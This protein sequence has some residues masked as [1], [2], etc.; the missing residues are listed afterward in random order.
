MYWV[1]LSLYI[2]FFLLIFININAKKYIFFIVITLSILAYNFDPIYVYGFG[3]NYY[4]DLIRI[5]NEIE[6]VRQL[7]DEYLYESA[8][9]SKIYISLFAILND[10]NLLPFFTC[11]F[12]YSIGLYSIYKIG[13]KSKCSNRLILCSIFMSVS[14]YNYL[15]VITNIRYLLALTIFFVILYLDLVCKKRIYCI[16]YII[17]ILFHPG[18]IILLIIRFLTLKNIKNSVM[19]LFMMYIC[20]NFFLDDIFNI[21]INISNVF[22]SGLQSKMLI[23][24]DIGN[25][26]KPTMSFYIFSIIQ[27]SILSIVIYDIKKYIKVNYF[28]SYKYFINIGILIVIISVMMLSNYQLLY[29]ITAILYLYLPVIAM[30]DVMNLRIQRKKYLMVSRYIIFGILI[31]ISCI[32]Y[33]GQEYGYNILMF[34]N[35]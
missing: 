19:I 13:K 33:F 18:I 15:M 5:F 17:D 34:S 3:D 16:G 24:R 4:T 1:L 23:Y 32:F 2:L 28:T 21:L 35:K 29:R 8:P 11:I 30:L 26:E 14:L 10:N 22:F 12:V 9:L 7:N 27:L 31:F 25:F 20:F 6:S